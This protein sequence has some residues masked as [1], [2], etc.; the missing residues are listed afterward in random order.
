MDQDV[1]GWSV[2]EVKQL[3]QLFD[4]SAIEQFVREHAFL[5]KRALAGFSKRL[6]PDYPQRIARFLTQRA[7]QNQQTL[8]DLIKRWREQNSA[9]CDA[10]QALEASSTPEA[11]VPLVEQ[12]GGVPALYALRTDPRAAELSDHIT[13]L[14]SGI[15]A[16]T[17]AKMP[18]AKAPARAKPASAEPASAAQPAA[19]G[20]ATKER[21]A[22]A[23]GASAAT[24]AS[25][26]GG[27]T[28]RS[29]QNGAPKS[30][31][32][33]F[34]AL[35]AE[36]Q[37]LQTAGHN[38]VS[39]A[40]Q[41]AQPQTAQDPQAL[42]RLI[43]K[44]SA[45]RQKII[46]ALTRFAALDSEV[47]ENIRAETELA[48][49]DGLVAGLV[50]S[51]PPPAAPTTID[52]AQ[53][54]LQTLREARTRLETSIALN[55]QRRVELHALPASIERLLNEI[56]ILGGMRTP[57][58][59]SLAKLEAGIN[60][61][62][63]SQQVEQL[64]E[65]ARRI[66]AN[67]LLYRNDLLQTWHNRLSGACRAGETLLNKSLHLSADLPEITSVETALERARDLLKT[68]LAPNPPAPIPFSPA[69]L[70]ESHQQLIQGQ[71]RLRQ[72][73]ANYNPQAALAALYRF[74]NHPPAELTH[75]QLDE[76]GA[77]LVGAASLRE[78]YEGLIW[79]IG[80]TLLMTLDSSAAEQFYERFGFTAIA[81][82]TAASLRSGDF[83][84]GLT[85]AAK[86][87]LFYT[88]ADIADVF[89]HPRTLDILSDACATQT[90]PM[91]SPDCFK[92][93]SPAIR[94]AALAF[95]RIAS[96]IHLQAP[97]QLQLS[98]ALL[99][100][101]DTPAEQTQAGRLFISALIDQGQSLN[102]YCAW[103]ALAA[104]HNQL[105]ADPIGTDAL[106]SL[107]WRLTLDTRSS[108][109]QLAALC[110]DSALQE[111]SAYAPGITLALALGS[112][113][114]A[115]ADHAVGAGARAT[116]G[117][118]SAKTQFSQ[119]PAAVGAG[120]T[121]RF[122]DMLHDQHPYPTLSDILR[123]RLPNQGLEPGAEDIETR[124]KQR[125]IR[126]TLASLAENLTEADRRI[127]LSHYRYAPTKQ[128]RNQ[129]DTRLKPLLTTLQQG[130]E[131]TGDLGPELQ[132]LDTAALARLVINDE[133]RIRKQEGRDSID[134][135]DRNKLRRDLE[136][137][138]EYL[139]TANA[140][141]A[142]LIALGLEPTTIAAALSN[143]SASLSAA[144]SLEAIAQQREM[145][146]ALESELHR[147][148]GEAPQA[149]ALLQRALP[150]LS[151]DLS[152]TGA[153]A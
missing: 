105:Y 123:A 103:R 130:Q 45:A 120:Q 151:L 82:A 141:R 30:I 102:A 153:T 41:L 1:A 90:F 16:G 57:L 39:W 49:A 54:R 29:G 101:T 131:P 25:L 111:I 88:V 70:D 127:Q 139:Q 14:R 84:L 128:L 51:L 61:P 138:F 126:A 20:T 124:E 65:Q 22:Q 119:A 74:E 132:N 24:P 31:S 152:Q 78:G 80:A 129:I 73:L 92:D 50:A 40:T 112:L 67:A 95:L 144:A 11:F 96:Q 107:L 79:R 136:N 15:K 18:A 110:S 3:I 63:S 149:Q 66:Y 116:S 137:L 135:D 53:G 44:L 99:A 140:K 87:H 97:L 10:I 86:E 145:Q 62:T 58:S 9:L 26:S 56:V 114:L 115:R 17:F 69:Q 43:E 134:G 98:A 147:L 47:L 133:E 5:Q 106:S 2:E 108:S 28:S 117:S 42:Q 59:V 148:I 7:T 142:E 64:L 77:A 6:P 81:T 122:L 125:A 72:V 48:E 37:T 68:P 52:G 121:A 146:E 55:E 23:N 75:Q 27:P 93:V 35:E 109:A 46:D 143:E 71:E 60:R 118:E 89:T 100:A 19:N 113:A 32:A 94:Q 8:N 4:R 104:R 13:A 83:P 21:P 38:I 91:A 12:H 85:F 33:S 36:V 150:D 76:I 34:A